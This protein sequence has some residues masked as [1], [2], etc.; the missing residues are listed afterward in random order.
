MALWKHEK[1]LHLLYPVWKPL[2]KLN[3]LTISS[4][5]HHFVANAHKPIFSGLF[6][7]FKMIEQNPL[8]TLMNRTALII[9]PSVT[10]LVVS[11][12]DLQVS[13]IIFTKK[14]EQWVFQSCL[15]V[16]KKWQGR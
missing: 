16:S 4:V 12:M 10:L 3:V 2:K 5:S 8:W 9:G 7:F 11:W 15:N 13:D 14:N 6:S 1:Q